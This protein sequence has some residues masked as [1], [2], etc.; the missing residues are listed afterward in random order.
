M[1]YTFKTDAKV[2]ELVVIDRA[3]LTG[4][5]K[6]FVDNRPV[7]SSHQ[8][9]RG[10][11]GTFYPLKNGTLEIRSPIFEVVPSVWCNENWV[12][13]VPPVKG[14]QYVLVALPLISTVVMTFGQILGLVIGGLAVGVSYIVMRSQRSANAR[15]LICMAIAIIAPVIAF[16]LV[17]AL[18]GAFS[19]K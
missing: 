4:K 13:L 12:E 2:P 18:S 17:L 6:V 1:K 10:A 15:N 7:A 5:V 11:A 3:L 9:R 19:P 8:G 16:V 14:W